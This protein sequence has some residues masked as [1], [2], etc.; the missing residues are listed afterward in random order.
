MLRL[1]E[2]VE[3]E[4]VLRG[5]L[6]LS[7]YLDDAPSDPA[8]RAVWRTRLDQALERARD[9]VPAGSD[10][11]AFDLAAGLLREE[12]A[13]VTSA[14]GAA[15]W[16]AYVTPDAV[17]LRASLPV[18]A[19]LLVRWG[20]GALVAPALRALKESR[21]A[22]VAIVDSRSA[23]IL[24]Y[25]DGEIREIES[26][27]AYTP[28][29]AASHMGAPPRQG[30]HP[31]TRG[32]AGRDAAERELRAG[33]AQMM[34]ELAG[35]MLDAAGADGWLLFGGAPAAAR[36]AFNTMP[37]SAAPRSLLMPDVPLHLGDAHIARSAARGASILRRREDLAAV[38]TLFERS[39]AGGRAATGYDA[40]RN[41]LAAG[42]AQR[43]LITTRSVERAPE[44]A[45]TLVR[46]AFAAGTEIEIVSGEAAE[47]LD[48]RAEGAGALLRFMP[49]AA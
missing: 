34:R 4:R 36:E 7:V 46:A 32:E 20:D 5:S 28:I 26:L 19:A 3:I 33:R 35:R 48:G 31:G 37:K 16:M 21:A 25:R 6:A 17:R 15:G 27:K 38:H 12:L 9:D 45:E 13:S 44:E 2:I 10:R 40:V 14:R 47:L 24:R 1:S 49:A 43:L 22:I 29:S 42:A 11:Q 39:G 23:R 41:A 18:P 30:F 8:Q